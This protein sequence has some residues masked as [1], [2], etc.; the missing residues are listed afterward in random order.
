MREAVS[1]ISLYFSLQFT[2]WSA[3][4]WQIYFDTDALEVG[5]NQGGYAYCAEVYG[6]TAGVD[7]LAC[8]ALF[9]AGAAF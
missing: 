1:R 7:I 9:Q 6:T 8:S 3:C 5:A 2:W 4:K